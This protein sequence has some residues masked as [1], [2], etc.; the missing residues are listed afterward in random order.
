MI[1]DEDFQKLIGWT[2][3]ASQKEVLASKAR[4][5]VICAG[6]RWGKSAISGYLVAKRFAQGLAD[7]KD[8]KRDSIKIWIVAPSYDLCKKVF[9]YAVKFLRAANKQVDQFVTDRP[10]SQIKISES[11]WLQCRSADNPTSLLGEE[12]DLLIIDE[13]ANISKRIWYDYLLPTT[14]SKTRQGRTIF[15]STPRGKNWFYDIYLQAKERGGAFHFTSLDGAEINQSE[16][17]RLKMISPTDWFQQNYEATFLEKASAVFRGVKEANFPADII[18]SPPYTIAEPR[19][20][21]YYVGGLDLAQINDFT[22]LRIFDAAT[23]KEV[24]FDRFHRIT[25]PLQIQRIEAACKKYGA[26]VTVELNNIGL[27][28][29]DELKSRGVRVEDFH[30]TGSI[31]KDPGKRGSKEELI[32]KL[33]VDIENRNIKI[34][35]IEVSNDELEAYTHIITPAGNITF[36]APEGGHDDCVMALALANWGL[37]GK[38]RQEQADISRSMPPKVKRFQ[39]L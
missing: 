14:A 23:H 3:H 17:D 2:P 6:R 13:A 36:G 7:I 16:W 22:V 39:Y 4:E 38:Q 34:A 9:E 33:A 19:A 31:S 20:G 15:I 35:P 27:A 28:V 8:G 10:F 37:L 30:T 25:Y 12:L 5:I 32:N 24:Y 11:I 29:A 21:T 1:K 26:R 18:G